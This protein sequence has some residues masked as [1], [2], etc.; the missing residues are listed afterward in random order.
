MTTEG[1]ERKQRILENLFHLST[2]TFLIMQFYTAVLG[3]LKKYVVMFRSKDTTVDKLHDEQKQLVTRF[4]SNFIKSEVLKGITPKKLVNFA[5][6]DP[7]KPLATE[8]Y[9]CWMENKR[10]FVKV[11]Q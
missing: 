7:A 3:Q 8:R 6:S 11:W 2:K 10:S 1:K 4:L 9:F 5:V